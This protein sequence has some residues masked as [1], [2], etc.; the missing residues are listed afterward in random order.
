MTLWLTVLIS[1][2]AHAA[3]IQEAFAGRATFT[4]GTAVW[5]HALGVMH[6]TLQMVN[7]K[8]AATPLAFDVWPIFIATGG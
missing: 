7:Y 2:G 3:Q 5:N 8:A 1:F 4:S 6:P